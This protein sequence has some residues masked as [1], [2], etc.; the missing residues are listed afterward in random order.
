MP[1]EIKTEHSLGKYKTSNGKSK[2]E[3]IEGNK[4]ATLNFILT[5]SYF[6]SLECIVSSIE[7]IYNTHFFFVQAVNNSHS[8]TLFN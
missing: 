2:Q 5:S 8:N 4:C 1:I 3:S 7:N 6:I